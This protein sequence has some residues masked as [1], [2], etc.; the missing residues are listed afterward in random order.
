MRRRKYDTPVFQSRHPALNEYISAA[1]KAIGD[2][3]VSVRAEQ[4]AL[5]Y[6]SRRNI[7]G[8]VE[9]VV[10]VIKDKENIPLERFVFGIRSMI[11]VEAFDKDSRSDSTSYVQSTHLT[12][13]RYFSV[14]GAMSA[15]SLGQYFRSFLVRLCMIESQLGHLKLSGS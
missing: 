10:M 4:L 9:R 8:N 2:E 14:E 15:K 12:C 7:K 3:L 6:N 1:V 13:S 5:W 11:E